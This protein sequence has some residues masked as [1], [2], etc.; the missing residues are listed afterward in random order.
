MYS[1]KE[2][3]ILYPVSV[4]PM[5]DWT[6]R[7]FRYFLRLITKHTLLYTEMITTGAILRGNKERHLAFSPEELPLALQLGGD[8]PKALAESSRIGQD[9]GYTEINLNVGCPSDKVQEGNFGACLM[10]DP[11]QVAEMIAAMS[12]SVSVPVTVKCRIGIPGKDRFDDLEE[13]VS[14][15]SRAGAERITI[16]ARIAILDGLSPAQNRSVPPLRYEDVYEIK[17]RFPDLKIELNGGVKTLEEISSHLTRVD[18]VMI[19]RAAYENPF[20]FSQVDSLFYGSTIR[21]RTRREIFGEMQE[22]VRAKTA[23]GEKP[24][25]I[26]RHLLGAFHEIRGARS[27]RR[28]LTEKMHSNPSPNLLLE[29]LG[30]IPDEF[31]DRDIGSVDSS[32]SIASES[33]V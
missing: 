32:H 17:R 13:F 16:H 27:Y 4:A 3:P 5:M 12:S 26:L 9:Y 2:K 19:G 14:I 10:R 29:A 28:I 30:S 33:V 8:D 1:V 6:D 31:L 11:N 23:D 24:S 15:V 20:L 25:R 21:K 22:Y 18:G 7:H